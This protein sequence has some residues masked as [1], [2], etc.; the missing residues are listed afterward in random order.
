MI[1]IICIPAQNPF[2]IS[3]KGRRGTEFAEFS[4]AP[5]RPLRESCFIRHPPILPNTPL[6]AW[7]AVSQLFRQQYWP[8]QKLHT[9]V[10]W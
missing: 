6:P 1:S 3:R 10:R 4:S 8:Q 2:D 9:S 7:Y 5:Q